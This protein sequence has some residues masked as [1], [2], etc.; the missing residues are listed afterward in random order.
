M[1]RKICSIPFKIYYAFSFWFSFRGFAFCCACFI[2]IIRKICPSQQLFKAFIVFY[3]STAT[4]FGLHWPSSGGTHNI[5][6]KEVIIFTTDPLSAVQ[7][8]LCT[9]FDKCCHR[10]SKCDCEVSTG[11]CSHLVFQYQKLEVWLLNIAIYCIAG[12]TETCNLYASTNEHWYAGFQ[13][14]VSVTMKCSV[15]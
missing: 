13:V 8:V 14:F 3:T 12:N 15:F 10:L 9:L 1:K 6:Y 11:A 5:I 7:I 2:K 4:C